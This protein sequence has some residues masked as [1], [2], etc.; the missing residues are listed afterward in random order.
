[1]ARVVAT[2]RESEFSSR[3]RSEEARP[4]AP[5]GGGD[6]AP[7]ESTAKTLLQAYLERN[8]IPAARLEREGPFA[9]ETLRRWRLGEVEMRR[10]QMVRVLGALQR[11]TNKPVRI[12][13]IFDLDPSNPDN[14]I[15]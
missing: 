2:G 8:G 5:A 7:A 6:Q 9:R 12:E 13:E 3:G 15:D 4:A 11:I 10:K 14:W 1:L